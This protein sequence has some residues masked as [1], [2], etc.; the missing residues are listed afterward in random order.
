LINPELDPKANSSNLPGEHCVQHATV[1]IR[2]DAAATPAYRRTGDAFV[3]TSHMDSVPQ[4]IAPLGIKQMIRFVADEFLSGLARGHGGATISLTSGRGAH[5]VF[6]ITV[7]FTGELH[8]SPTLAMLARI[9]DT[10][11]EANDVRV[12]NDERRLTQE[13]FDAL[14]AD[15]NNARPEILRL[16][17]CTQR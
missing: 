1:Q 14:V 17:G 8:Y 11:V 5:G 12:R 2:S 9:G 4:L 10:I 16:D 13:F 6:H 15:F 7:A 3:L